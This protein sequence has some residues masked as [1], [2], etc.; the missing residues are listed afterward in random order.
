MAKDN[1]STQASLYAR[2]RPDYPQELYDF[3]L[4]H[5]TGRDLAL[6]CA[7]GNGQAAVVLAR[8]FKKVIGIDI[9]ENQLLNAPKVENLEYR[10]GNVEDSQL[11]PG[12]FD[13]ITVA[14]AIHWF[15][16]DP[17]FK[18]VTRISKPNAIFA[19]WA[20]RL[21]R[22]NSEELN[23][24]IDDL[25]S[26]VLK[27]YWDAERIHVENEYRSIPFPFKEIPN[28]GFVTKLIYHE[29]DLLG[30]FNTWS[31]VQHFIRKN[32]RNP[33]DALKPALDKVFSNS[34]TVEARFEIFMRAGTV[35]K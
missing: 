13:L 24:I 20:Y 6:D 5:T 28:P 23:N 14:T 2:F 25:Y 27:G 19:C 32:G 9:S 11:P 12:S 34:K 21:L 26:R 22:T 16:F 3:L 4:N 35:I 17:F 1:F 29:Q 7:T 30:L 8:H 15:K 18:E 10:I 31:A 33:V